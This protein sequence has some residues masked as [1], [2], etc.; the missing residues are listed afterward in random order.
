M[1]ERTER[2]AIL[3]ETH[4]L[5]L[6]EFKIQFESDIFSASDNRK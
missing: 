2:H 5:Y 1:A 4:I 3:T 6:I